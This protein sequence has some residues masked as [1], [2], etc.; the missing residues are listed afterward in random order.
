VNRAKVTRFD[1]VF[2]ES[3]PEHKSFIASFATLGGV[4]E[5]TFL[6]DRT[7]PAPNGDRRELGVVLT[8]FTICLA[9]GSNGCRVAAGGDG[10]KAA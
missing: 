4:Q 10:R 7:M 2:A 3:V 8:S 5:V 6:L 1:E 9:R